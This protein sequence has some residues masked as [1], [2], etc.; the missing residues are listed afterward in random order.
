MFDMDDTEIEKLDELEQHTETLIKTCQQLENENAQLKKV[1]K[2]LISENIQ[3][4]NIN[5]AARERVAEII[6]KLK[7]TASESHDEQSY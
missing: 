2:Q 6:S 7:A 1:H 3:L 5:R 4:Q